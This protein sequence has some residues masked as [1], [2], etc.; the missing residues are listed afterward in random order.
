MRTVTVGPCLRLFGLAL[1]T[2]LTCG[3]CIIV[4]TWEWAGPGNP[5]RGR[6]E[7]EIIGAIRPGSTTREDALLLLGEPDATIKDERVFAYHWIMN[8]GILIGGIPLGYAGGIDFSGPI[9]RRYLLFVEF[10]DHGIVKRYE[11]KSSVSFSRSLD[12]ID[13]W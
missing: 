8:T 12:E 6:L 9:R 11:L 3:G 4:P 5:T 2:S 7:Q 1:A 13:Q 10:D